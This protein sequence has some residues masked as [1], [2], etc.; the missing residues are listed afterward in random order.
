M[1]HQDFKINF[2]HVAIFITNQTLFNPSQLHVKEI[3]LKLGSKGI[4]GLI[5]T[6]KISWVVRSGPACLRDTE[7]LVKS[8][9][10]YSR[11]ADHEGAQSVPV[12]VRLLKV[13]RHTPLKNIQ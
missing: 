9:L 8:I 13:S 4:P 10:M 12:H 1:R 6:L 2:T 7:R 11:L 5:T 3:I